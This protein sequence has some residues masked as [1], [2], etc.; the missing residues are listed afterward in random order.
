[1]F[2][3][4]LTP[5]MFRFYGLVTILTVYLDPKPW[6]LFSYPNVLKISPI[7][8]FPFYAGILSFRK[9]LPLITLALK[10]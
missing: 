2:G 1:M 3:A 9:N 7:E 5:N 8:F 4:C 10:H 6:D